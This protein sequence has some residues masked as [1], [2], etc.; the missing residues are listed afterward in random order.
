MRTAN[1]I[2]GLLDIAEGGGDHCNKEVLGILE[3]EGFVTKTDRPLQRLNAD[4]LELVDA[5]FKGYH[6]KA[7]QLLENR[8]N[9]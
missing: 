2:R 6:T 5:L 7:W 9:G 4:G 3:D 8:I 1:L